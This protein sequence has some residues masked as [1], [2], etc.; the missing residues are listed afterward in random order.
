MTGRARKRGVPA[1]S[2]HLPRFFVPRVGTA[3]DTVALGVEEARHA[4][5][6]RLRPG[7]AVVLIDGDGRGALGR[8]ESTGASGVVIRSEALL[9]ER[10]GESPLALTLAVAALKAERFDWVVEKATELGVTRIVPFTSARTLASPSAPR[11]ERWRQI[12]LAAA[13]QSGRSVVP[14]V[15]EPIP[16]AAV[17]ELPAAARV[18]FAEDGDTDALSGELFGGLPSLVAVVGPEGGFTAAEFAAARAAGCH[19]AG[20]GPRILRA[21]TAAIVAVVM[22]QTELG[23]S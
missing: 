8:V 9:P 21:E 17:L 2:A 18:L 14:E 20:L 6:R 11:R 13:K 1:A 3:G 7:E 22:C 5:V 4:R 16:F 19:L 15:A 23:D 12:A 10:E